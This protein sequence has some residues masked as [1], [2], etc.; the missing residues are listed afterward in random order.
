MTEQEISDWERE[1][2][3]AAKMRKSRE[4]WELKEGW[5][6]RNPPV[7]QPKVFQTIRTNTWGNNNEK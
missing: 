4:G 6:G 3:H 2:N 7:T 1:I 5:D